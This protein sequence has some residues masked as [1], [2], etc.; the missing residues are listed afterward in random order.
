MGFIQ[1]VAKR[2]PSGVLSI[3]T[4]LAAPVAALFGHPEF[5]PVFVAVAAAILGL[6]TQVVPTG[7]AKETALEAAGEAA[8]HVAI[9]L[10]SGS[11]GKV[12]E[13]TDRGVVVVEDALQAASGLI[14]GKL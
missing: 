3:L 4:F 8:S 6:R 14:G 7:K 10:T 9:N 5:A 1:A 13:V 12:G 11:A 2:D